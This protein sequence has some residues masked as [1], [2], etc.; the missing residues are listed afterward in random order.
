MSEDIWHRS[1]QMSEPVLLKLV[2][3]WIESTD[4]SLCSQLLVFVR[5][6]KEKK[7]VEKFLFF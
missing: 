6:V 5:Y 2:F 7:V 1:L 3:S 4:V